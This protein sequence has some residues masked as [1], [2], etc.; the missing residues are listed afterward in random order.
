MSSS[1]TLDKK[2]QSFATYPGQ[3]LSS[4]KQM[5]LPQFLVSEFLLNMFL[6]A[7]EAA[8]VSAGDQDAPIERAGAGSESD[9]DRSSDRSDDL[10]SRESCSAADQV[11]NI[12]NVMSHV[13]TLCSCRNPRVISVIK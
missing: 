1:L 10:S 4:P 12:V 5:S 11:P 2:V 7:G 8:N 6:V 3:D 13:T 9:H